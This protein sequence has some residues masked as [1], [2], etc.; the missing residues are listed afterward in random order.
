MIPYATTTRTIRNIAALRDHGWRLLLTPDIH[1]DHGMPY[2]LDNGAWGCF[3]R[4]E[5]FNAEAFRDLLSEYAAG[6]DWIVVPDIV[7]GGLE[8][9]AVS[10]EW[11]P[12]LRTLGPTLL[13]PVQDGMTDEHLRNL[14]SGDVGIFVGGS[15]EWKEQ[16]LTMWGALARETGCYLHVGRVNSRRRI[17]LCALAGAHSF[18]GTSVTRFAVNVHTL[19]AETRQGALDFGEAI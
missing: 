9:L 18:D 5:S 2:G 4:G 1:T 8:S 19:T 16:S 7:C 11:L 13:I 3:Q 17:R 15:T 14:V 6:A 12:E 10:L